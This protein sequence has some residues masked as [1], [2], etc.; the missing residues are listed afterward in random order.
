MRVARPR[1]WTRPHTLRFETL[2]EARAR[3]WPRR[4]ERLSGYGG[5][6]ACPRSGGRRSLDDCRHCE[7]FVCLRPDADHDCG[8][9]RCLAC[10]DDSLRDFHGAAAHRVTPDTPVA[11]ARLLTW[12]HHTALL[13]VV[14]AGAVEGVIYAGQL[15]R[16]QG[17]VGRHMVREPWSLTPDST[18]GDAV[19]AMRELGV[20]ALI[21]VDA[22]SELIG[23]IAAADLR[24]IGLAQPLLVS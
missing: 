24:R 10:D 16:A 20:P 4:P 6:V 7:H 3:L 13:L 2:A 18:L 5:S 21:V 19:E 22:Q 23:V 11:S 12:V 8:T 1:R 15:Q 14:D 17:E 9:L